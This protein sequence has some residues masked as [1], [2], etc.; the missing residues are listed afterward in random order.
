MA[1]ADTSGGVLS[2]VVGEEAE[3]LSSRGQPFVVEIFSGLDDALAALEA[4]EPDVVATGFQTL[5]WLTPL[6]E[7]LANA[8]RA[9]PRVVVITDAL[10]EDIVL[11]LPLVVMKEGTL[12]VA[13]LPDF[14]VARFGA[15]LLGPALLPKP[16]IRALWR[17]VR[18]ELRDVDLIR[19]EHM[20]AMIGGRRNPLA[21]LFGATL[22]RASARRLVIDDGF[23]SYLARLGLRAR[24]EIARSHRRW[25]QER[26]PRFW[27]AADD[28]EIARIFSVL[29][30]QQEAWQA[31][32]NTKSD[33]DKPAYRSFWERMAIDGGEA[34]RTACFALEAGGEIVATV[35]GL[36][37][38]G[39]FTLLRMSTA[40]RRWSH[41]APGR[42]AILETVRR[43]SAD[44][45]TR[46]DFGPG[47]HPLKGDFGTED[48]ALYDLVVAQD[49]VAI[50]RVVMHELYAQLGP[51]R[52]L[53]KALRLAVPRLAGRAL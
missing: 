23:E 47:C 34:G 22:S 7:D 40:G 19:L 52:R 28:E 17:A 37:H 27:R 25:Q 35:F 33:F 11:A 3:T 4:I 48:V 53:R 51:K 43:L 9:E 6:Y 10:S 13:V 26:E 39:T 18:A 45:I 38:D 16:A 8:H 32:R 50:P 42:L 30:E 5:D 49:V 29:E 14:G 20:P 44:G 46:F 41:L 24:K 12:R 1:T 15:P 36:I 2:D 31:E 21:A